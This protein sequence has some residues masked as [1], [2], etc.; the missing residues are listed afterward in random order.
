[1]YIKI[2][3]VSLLVPQFYPGSLWA[4]AWSFPQAI[5][6]NVLVSAFEDIRDRQSDDCKFTSTRKQKKK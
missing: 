4:L 2:I 1:M 5:V 6:C 3:I